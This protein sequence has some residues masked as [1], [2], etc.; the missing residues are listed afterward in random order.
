MRLCGLFEIGF[1]TSFSAVLVGGLRRLAQRRSPSRQ[2]LISW[3]LLFAIA[4]LCLIVVN[5]RGARSALPGSDE[6]IRI[7]LA[8]NGQVRVENRFGDVAVRVTR[9]KDVVVAA[10]S[11]GGESLKHSPVVIEKKNDLLLISVEPQ[12][13]DASVRVNLTIQIP[14]TA[15]AEIV[16]SAGA[17]KSRGLSTS[18][19]LNTISG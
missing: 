15:R 1:P 5:A 9:A 8:L 16:T 12:A 10:S 3:L 19:S 11:S 7:E 18:L 17:I 2:I 4:I 13:S 14:E 6:G